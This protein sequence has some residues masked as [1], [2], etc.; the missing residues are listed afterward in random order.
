MQSSAA[1]ETGVAV[2][3][4]SSTELAACGPD[5]RRPLARTISPLSALTVYGVTL[6]SDILLSPKERGHIYGY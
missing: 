5:L 2:D 4:A 6:V 3:L 1:L